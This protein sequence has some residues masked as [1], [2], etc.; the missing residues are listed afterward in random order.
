MTRRIEEKIAENV[1]VEKIESNTRTG[2]TAVYITLV[3]GTRETGK[4][5]DDIKLKLDSI[6]DLP[7]GAGPIDFV[8]DFGDTAALMLTV[9]SP[10]VDDAEVA[11]RAQALRKEIEATRAAATPTPAARASRW[12]R[13]FPPRC[14]PSSCGGRCG[15][16]RKRRRPTVCSATRGSSSVRASSAWTAP[17]TRT[18][19]RCVNTCE[20]FT[21]ERLRASEFHPDAWPVAVIRDPADTPGPAR[22][23]RPATS[24]AIASSTTTPI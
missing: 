14:R 11:A 17:P 1:R 22:G 9:A 3:E 24:T 10:R 23:G 4:E 20:R 8:K 16:S 6:T 5:F 12:C 15:C 18:M 19:R 7:D 21:R 2:I 13:A